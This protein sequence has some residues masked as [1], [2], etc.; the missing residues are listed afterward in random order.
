MRTFDILQGDDA[1]Y[2]M[3]LAIPTA[4]EFK[5]LVTPKT[6][7]LSASIDDFVIDKLA[8]MMTGEREASFT[9]YAAQRGLDLEPEAREAYEFIN[10]VTVERAGFYTDDEIRYGASPDG[11]VGDDGLLE[12]KCL[13]QANCVYFMLKNEVDAD[14][15]P[16]IQGQL[17]VTGRQWVD[18]FLYHPLL[19]RFGIRVYREEAYIT[20]LQEALGV[21]TEKMDAAMEN[22]KAR[23]L[24]IVRKK[25][26]KDFEITEYLKAG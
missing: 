14:H 9:S 18:W 4:S 20:L 25:P 2:N 24:L 16:Q 26:Y 19:P 3:R 8:E 23:G 17:L 10:G 1:W 7:K 13:N 12:I 15:M 11:L 5:R 6:K 22:L 21:F